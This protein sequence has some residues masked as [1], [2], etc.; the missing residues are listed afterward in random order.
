MSLL[1]DT[2]TP[3]F[4]PRSG[5]D[6]ETRQASRS[7][8]FQTPKLRSRPGTVPAAGAVPRSSMATPCPRRR[9]P[10]MWMTSGSRSCSARSS[11]MAGGSKVPTTRSWPAT[12]AGCTTDRRNAAG[13]DFSALAAQQPGK[14]QE[15]E[16]QPAFTEDQLQ[17][18]REIGSLPAHE[19]QLLRGMAERRSGSR[20]ATPLTVRRPGKG[21]CMA[22]TRGRSGSVG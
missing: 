14:P 18:L 16:P 5:I 7:V 11:R 20:T 10:A 21:I 13:A 8:S 19:Q 15:A 1:I 22:P 3:R 4:K 17:A 6:D 9:S 12:R 2:G